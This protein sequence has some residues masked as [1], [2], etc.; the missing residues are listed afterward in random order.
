MIVEYT[1]YN[2]DE[3]RRAPFERVYEKPRSSVPQ[4]IAWVMSSLTARKSLRTTFCGSSGIP[5]KAI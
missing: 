4:A 2:I 1:R 5:R 3:K